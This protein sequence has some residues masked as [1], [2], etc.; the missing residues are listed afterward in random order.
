MSNERNGKQ[1][2]LEAQEKVFVRD[3]QDE[4]MKAVIAKEKDKKPKAK[5][6]SSSKIS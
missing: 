2:L 3:L 5:K 1:S 4:F 6:G